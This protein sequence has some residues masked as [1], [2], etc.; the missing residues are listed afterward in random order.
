MQRRS[1][2]EM[3]SADQARRAACMLEMGI[4]PYEVFRKETLKAAKAAQNSQQEKMAQVRKEQILKSLLLEEQAWCRSLEAA[5]VRKVPS[6]GCFH[7]SDNSTY[8]VD[9]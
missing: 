9:P 3:K 8:P 7:N 1:K 4:N 5:A 2:L 6:L